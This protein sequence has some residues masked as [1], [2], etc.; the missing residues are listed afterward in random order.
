[1]PESHSDGA[2]SQ[3]LAHLRNRVYV[4]YRYAPQKGADIP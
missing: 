3:R 1:M 4:R 2:R